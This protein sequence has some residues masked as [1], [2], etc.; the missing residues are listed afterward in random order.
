MEE[1][2]FCEYCGKKLDENAKFCKECGKSTEEK[3]EV[4]LTCECGAIYQEGQKF[5]SSCGAKVGKSIITKIKTEGAS[6]LEK[7]KM[8]SSSRLEK[9]KTERS[10]K[11]IENPKEDISS[12]L[13]NEITEEEI[14]GNKLMA[15]LSYLGILIL[16]PL[17]T[18][19]EVKY[20][21]FHLNQGMVLGIAYIILYVILLI[22]VIGWIL[23][24]IGIIVTGIFSIMGIISAARGKVKRVPLLGKI[25]ILK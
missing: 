23:G 10:L 20:I 11:K 6:T 21:R 15:V 24:L 16:I 19:R 18:K 2:K 13:E 7:I 22:P 8:E 17:L 5:C 3:E 14:Q 9:I 1:K 25:K 4:I 12:D